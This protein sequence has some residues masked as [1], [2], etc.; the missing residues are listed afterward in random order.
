MCSL[1]GRGKARKTGGCSEEDSK[2]HS[3]KT[4]RL[5][6]RKGVAELKEDGT[7]CKRVYFDASSSKRARFSAQRESSALGARSE[8]FPLSSQA[9]LSFCDKD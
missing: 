7:G 1:R 6:R 3:R 4:G 8:G 2:S 9:G 5:E